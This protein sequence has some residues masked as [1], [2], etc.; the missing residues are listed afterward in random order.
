MPTQFGRSKE[1]DFKFIMDRIWKNLK[2][3]KEK[4]LSFEGRGVLIGAVSQ[5]IPTYFMSGFLLPK[6]L[7]E[8]IEKVVCAFWWGSKGNN[9]ER[10]IGLKRKL[11]KSKHKVG[12][13][14]KILRDFKLAML[15]NQVWRFHKQ[16]ESI[17]AKS[18]KAEYFPNTDILH[19]PIGNSPSFA[20]RSIQ[21]SI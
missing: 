8:K 19:A 11:F 5:A 10:S 13:G 12:M 15:A 6:G 1:Q 21:Q 18:Y 17:I 4:S 16:P 2:G 3:W 20:W 9:R 14:F 7:C